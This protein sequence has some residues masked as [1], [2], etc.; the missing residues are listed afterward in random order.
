M[1]E[2]VYF[3]TIGLFLGTILLVFGMRY[4]AIVKQAKAR[5]DSGEAY[6][7]L[8]EKAAVG[9]AEAAATLAAIQATLADLKTRL[10][11]VEK[12]LKDVE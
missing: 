2:H 12:I 11:A 1:S 8:A 6:R 7:Q 9:Q 10:A 5:L 3:L 4:F